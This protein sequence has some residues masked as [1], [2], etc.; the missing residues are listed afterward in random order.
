MSRKAIITI[1]LVLI[2]IGM[3]FI[4][5]KMS[6]SNSEEKLE[7][8][9]EEKSIGPALNGP[10]EEA[11]SENQTK[12][13]EK[14]DVKK[15][16]KTDKEQTQ[17]LTENATFLF[18]KT[19][20]GSKNTKDDEQIKNI[21]TKK[22]IK[23]IAGA[24]S[25]NSNREIDV[26]NT[27]IKFENTHDF[28]DKIIKGTFKYDLIVKSKDKKNSDTTKIN[29]QSAIKFIKEDDRYKLDEISK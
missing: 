5:I 16:A 8:K 11:N 9:Q 12:P 23:Q 25:K 1:T 3:V 17:E 22:M 15:V 27:S 2:I 19:I 24:D 10:K 21:A 7:T 6:N 28:K 18:K 20:E 26:R 14:K 29:Q 4:F 13:T